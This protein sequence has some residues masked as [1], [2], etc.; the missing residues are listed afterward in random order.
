MGH[1]CNNLLFIALNKLILYN[2]IVT[3]KLFFILSLLFSA[4]GY[5]MSAWAQTAASYTFT[6]FSRPY[7]GFPFPGW[8]GDLVSYGI[9]S[10]NDRIN[11]YPIG[12]TFNY[13]GSDYTSISACSNGFIS[14][15]NPVL[16]PHTNIADSITG[17]GMLMVYWDYLRGNNSSLSIGVQFIDSGIAPNRIFCFE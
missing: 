5:C 13:C 14:F 1:L 3:K 17:P 10:F 2:F 4:F 9:S 12:F 8:T 16:A 11:A 15:S 6:A 7:Q